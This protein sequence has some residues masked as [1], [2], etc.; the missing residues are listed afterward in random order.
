MDEEI[1][2]AELVNRKIIGAKHKKEIEKQIR[3]DDTLDDLME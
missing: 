1:K 3:E 2:K